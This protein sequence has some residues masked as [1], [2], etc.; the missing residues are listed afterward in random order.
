MQH[1]LKLA[2]AI[3]MAGLLTACG[4]SGDGVSSSADSGAENQA[5]VSAPTPLNGRISNAL[6]SGDVSGLE[7][8]DVGTI[9]DQAITEANGQKN[10]ISSVLSS[11]Y[12]GGVDPTLNIGTSTSNSVGVQSGTSAIPYIVADGGRGMAAV[13]GYGN[14][15]GMAYGADVLN[16]ITNGSKETQ[17]YP[18]FLRAFKWLLTGSGNGTL[19]STIKYA[20]SGYDTTV[21]NKFIVRTGAVPEAVSCNVADNSNNCWKNADVI[22]FGGSVAASNEL[23]AMVRKYLAAGKAVIYMHPGWWQSA[24]GTQVVSAMGMTLG[25]DP[26]NYYAAANN[27]KVSERSNAQVLSSVLAASDKFKN[28]A[29]SLELLKQN[30][31]AV[32]LTVD[33]SSV[34]PFTAALTDL[35]TLNSSRTDIFAGDRAHLLYRLLVLW[36]DMERP[37]TNYGTIRRSNASAFLKA[38]ASDAFQWFA[39]STATATPTGQGDYMP[40][41]AQLMIPSS[42]WEEIEVTIPQTSGTTLIGR[43]AIPG[44]GVQIEISDAA[45]AGTLGIQTSL[46]RSWGNPLTES[47]DTYARPLRPHSFNVSLKSGINNFVSPNGGPLML[48]YSG[49]TAD[50]IVKLRIKGTVK[51]SHFDYTRDMSSTDIS[52]AVAALNAGTYGW[53]T[54]KVTG[55][56]IQQIMKYAKNAI[57]SLSPEMYANTYI[58]DGLFMSNHIANGYNDAG[59][60]ATVSSLCNSF[61]WTCDGSVHKEPVVQHF[62]G[63]IAT[64]GFLCSGNPIDGSAGIGLGWGYAHEM[65]HNTVQRIMRIKPNGTNGCLVECDNNILASAT[66]LRVLETLGVNAD[67]GHP[68]DYVGTYADIVAARKLGLSDAAYLTEMQNRIW[69]DMKY[70]NKMRT[71]HFQLAFQFAKYRSSLTQPTVTSTLDYLALLTKG[72]RLVNKTFTLDSASKYGMS[73]Y[74]VA[75]AKSI[76]NHDLLYVLSSKIIGKDM[77]NIFWM[78]GIPLSN[79]ALNSVSDLGFAIAPYSFYALET[80][81]H[82]QLKLGQW[83]DL[84]NNSTPAWPYKN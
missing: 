27:V 35:S 50:T 45:G 48:S 3:S 32:N 66:A 5:P 82:N 25:G 26:G 46:L 68:L 83:I 16:W 63:W 33:T 19:P 59:M 17:H 62:V 56:E 37:S 61:D 39:R 52:E 41:S 72:D 74:T 30:A 22:I 1:F 75:T 34:A 24:G 7:T 43:G 49:A 51:Y 73:R 79:D 15:R 54:T 10:Y 84:S 21:V 9:L 58:R 60:T 18:L 53:Q 14:G 81:K 4:G 2:V 23:S 38:Y 12:G 8:S 67:S 71:L 40:A 42:E 31:P 11:I 65:G 13:T 70:Q 77:R 78:Y 47:S 36:A 80:G 6:V 44:K 76:S 28:L 64:C 57:G 69:S 55:G 29:A 20:V